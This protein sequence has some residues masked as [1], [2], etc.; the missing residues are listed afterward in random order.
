MVKLYLVVSTIPIVLACAVI[1]MYRVV[2]V[3]VMMFVVQIVVIMVMV[4]VMVVVVVVMMVVHVA[5]RQPRLLRRR[6]GLLHAET[7]G[8]RDGRW[9]G[10]EHER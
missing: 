9:T 5:V 8:G 6:T 1:V 4:V 7:Q 10:R 2:M 3:V